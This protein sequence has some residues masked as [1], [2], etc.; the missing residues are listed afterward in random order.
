MNQLK[1]EKDSEVKQLQSDNDAMKTV[2]C[3]LKPEAEF[4]N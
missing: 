2:L 3:E 4:C 1:A